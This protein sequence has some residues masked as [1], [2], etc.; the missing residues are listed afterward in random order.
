MWNGMFSVRYEKSVA[1]MDYRVVSGGEWCGE[2]KRL[3]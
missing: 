2:E 3:E 1:W